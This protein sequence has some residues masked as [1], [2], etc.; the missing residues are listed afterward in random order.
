MQVPVLVARTK[1]EYLKIALKLSDRSGNQTKTLREK[2]VS[3]GAF[4]IPPGFCDLDL[5]GAR[6]NT[7]EE[8]HKAELLNSKNWARSYERCIEPVSPTQFLIS[9]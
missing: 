4:S 9:L 8:S 3:V 5:A 2:L 6:G 7:V 1:S